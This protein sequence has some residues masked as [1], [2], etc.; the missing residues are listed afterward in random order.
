MFYLMSATF[1]IFLHKKNYFSIIIN[2]QTDLRFLI[3]FKENA[4]CIFQ[5][6][7]DAQAVIQLSKNFLFASLAKPYSLI[8]PR[9][10][11]LGDDSVLNN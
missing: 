6:I 8:K 3:N 7:F 11:P 5:H 4:M 2:I 9:I 10:V 1:L